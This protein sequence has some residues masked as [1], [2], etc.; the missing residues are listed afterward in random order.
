MKASWEAVSEKTVAN[1]F[2]HCYTSDS[3]NEE[4]V[5]NEDQ[6]DIENLFDR[7][8]LFATVPD[9]GTIDCF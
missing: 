8:R 9:D 6:L 3:M 4:T 7:L 5:V 2:R 1:L